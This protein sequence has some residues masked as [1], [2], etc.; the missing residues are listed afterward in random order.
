MSELHHLLTF[1]KRPITEEFYVKELNDLLKSG[2]PATYTLEQVAEFERNEKK[3][4]ED[5]NYKEEESKSDDEESSSNTTPLHIMSRSLPKD[6]TKSEEEVILKLMDILFEYGAGW[7]FIDYE[8]KTIGDLLLEWNSSVET[9]LYRRLV[10]A[11]VSA[12]LLLRVINGGEVEFLDNDNFAEFEDNDA[13]NS[14]EITTEQETAEVPQKIEPISADHEDATAAHSETFLNT[15]LEYTDDAL[16]TKTNRDG[17]MMDWE[18]NIMKLAA[19]T[20]APKHGATVINIGFGMGIIDTFLQQNK[21]AHHFICEA[22]P[23]VLSRMK[24]DGWY[25]RPGVTILEGR[26]QDTIPTLFDLDEPVFFD[27][28]YYDTFSEHYNDMLA[29]YDTIV[30]L[31][32]PEGVFSFFNGLG[33]DRRICYDVYKKIVEVDVSQYGLKCTYETINVEQDDE[34]WDEV[35]RSYYNCPVYYH[36][37]IRFA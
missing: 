6:L 19:N 22:H 31:L 11:G 29:L 12:E 17:V 23:D 35:R 5:P 10:D 24:K 14:Q 25:E 8:N 9:P 7:N 30:G 16:V 33:A 18:T 3:K 36:P 34:R 15:K 21:P 28:I 13:N 32:Q 1:P 20:L 26:W 4:L 27:G 37:I 2:I